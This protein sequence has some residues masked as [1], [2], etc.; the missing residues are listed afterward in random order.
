[1]MSYYVF[2]A[3]GGIALAAAF[4]RIAREFLAQSQFRAR[5]E[6]KGRV[7]AYLEAIRPA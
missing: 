2:R 1:M 5:F 6:G 4:P 3:R 7:R